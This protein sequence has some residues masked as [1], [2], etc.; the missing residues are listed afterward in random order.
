VQ[1]RR[2]YAAPLAKI[3]SGTRRT[4]PSQK[5]ASRAA[6]RTVNAQFSHAD[7]NLVQEHL[8]RVG[9][10]LATTVEEKRQY[11]ASQADGPGK[12][13]LHLTREFYRATWDGAGE[14]QSALIAQL[15]EQCF[16]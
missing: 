6:Q 1:D 14:Q 16:D 11:T 10:S 7:L 9:Q 12:A 2:A 15:T 4:T 8:S 13:F 3:E 5:G